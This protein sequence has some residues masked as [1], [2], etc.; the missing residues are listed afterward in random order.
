MFAR[1]LLRWY[2]Q[3][4]RDLPWRRSPS[5]YGTLVSEFMLQQ[6]VV[7]TVVPYFERFIARFPDLGSLAAATEDEVLTHWSGLGY[8][9]RARNLHRAARAVVAEHGGELPADE[10]TLLALPGVGSYTAAA[11][12]AI[13]FGRRTFALDGNAARVAARLFA[14][15]DPIDRP[16]VREDLRA[17]GQTL[18]PA[19]RAGDFAQAV[20]ELG[21]RVC[22][23]ANPRCGECPVARFCKGQALTDR[24]PARLPRRAKKV[25]RLD[26]V[27]VEKGG[28]VLLVKRQEGELLAGTWALPLVED[29]RRARLGDLREVGTIRHIFTHRDVTARVLRVRVRKVVDI[30][31]GRWVSLTDVQA[32][33]LSSFS[34]KMLSLLRRNP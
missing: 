29:V 15:A 22:V 9:R 1:S 16:A 23:T 10:E 25:V 3:V 12:A 20:M 13:A 21:A 7:A 14:V 30:P 17:R 11:I 26:C 32:L 5:P 18:V 19:R 34:R 4:R 33:P 27:A 24:I 8:Y 6:T 31:A 2:D 28:R